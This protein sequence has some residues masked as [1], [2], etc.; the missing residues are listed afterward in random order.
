MLFFSLGVGLGGAPLWVT[1]S[2]PKAGIFW[3]AFVPITLR[4]L[5]ELM[6]LKGSSAL[7]PCTGS[8]E[9]Q[10][11]TGGD[12]AKPTPKSALG[13]SFLLPGVTTHLPWVIPRS[14][15]IL[16]PGE[17]NQVPSAEEHPCGDQLCLCALGAWPGLT[18]KTQVLFVKACWNKR[19]CS[20][21]PSPPK[22]QRDC[23]GQGLSQP[24]E[25]AFEVSAL[26]W[27]PGTDDW[28]VPVLEVRGL[29][30]ELF[31]FL[32]QSWALLKQFKEWIYI[33]KVWTAELFKGCFFC[34]IPKLAWKSH[35]AGSDYQKILLQDTVG[36]V[37]YSS[38]QC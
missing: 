20:E 26:W 37:S 34:F 14:V 28:V 1:L 16:N 21:Q 13:A 3:S 23:K 2:H 33:L 24:L 9:R 11:L 32:C 18:C 17:V 4:H 8:E 36:V 5:T 31:T 29:S 22:L 19:R 10:S 6:M 27:P 30:S 35:L 12:P 15:K 7:A 38:F 25:I